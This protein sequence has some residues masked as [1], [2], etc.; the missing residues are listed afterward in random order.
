M[1]LIAR[2]AFMARNR[3]KSN[4]S[5]TDISRTPPRA[6]GASDIS[7]V[8]NTYILEVIP[9][10]NSSGDGC[11]PQGAACGKSHHMKSS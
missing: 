1:G 4:A 3:S 8:S 7:V 9:C 2:Q 5:A 10:E 11:T 6:H